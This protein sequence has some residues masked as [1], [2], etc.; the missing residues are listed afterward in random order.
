MDTK[1]IL[2]KQDVMV[3]H[4][5][6]SPGFEQEEVAGSCKQA[7]KISVTRKH[8]VKSRSISRYVSEYSQG[9]AKS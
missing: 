1:Y 2:K 4:G 9:Q 6:Q 7:N 8:G 3:R 5:L